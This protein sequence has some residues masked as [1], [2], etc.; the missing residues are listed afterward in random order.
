MT[1]TLATAQYLDLVARL[2]VR[3]DISLADDWADLRS[4]TWTRHVLRPVQ[5]L[6]RRRGYRLVGPVAQRGE[7]GDPIRLASLRAAC[8]TVIEEQVPGD[9][10]EAGVFRGG[11]TIMMR[12][13]LAAHDVTDRVV[14]AA[15]SFAG[16][17]PPAPNCAPD[18]GQEFHE[19]G[20]DVGVDEVRANFAKYGLL[21]D[22][23]RFLVGW[24]ADTLPTA[25]IERLAVLRLDGD[26][27]S[28][29]MDAIRPLYD[30]VVVGGF[31]IVD[32]YWSIDATRQAIDDYRDEHHIDAP[33]VT[34]GESAF[35]RVPVRACP[36]S[37]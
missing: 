26:L 17:P 13:V 19:H 10:L 11:M 30:K 8:E 2:L 35:W 34:A 21:D 29:T 16:V 1:T 22:Q 23:V 6:L 7:T 24:F 33:M 37:S 9:L 15:D 18:V 36:T 14:W 12:A 27:Y 32:D 25:P 20:L 5:Q 3:D 28:S 4:T 31:V